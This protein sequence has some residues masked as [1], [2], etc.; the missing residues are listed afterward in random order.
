MGL[1]EV[2]AQ[3]SFET[4]EGREVA[5]DYGDA[6]A[7]YEAIRSN[8]ALID[9]SARGKLR[10]T[11]A[12]R[13]RFLHGMLTNTVEDVQPGKGNHT[14]LTDPKGNTQADLHLYNRG[15]AMFL[16]F[17]P[18]LHTSAAAFLDRYL[19]GDDVSIEDVSESWSVLGIQGPLSTSVL[20][21][22]GVE[23]P[24]DDHESLAFPPCPD[25]WIVKRGYAADLGFDVWLPA[26]EGEATWTRLVEAGA[27][28][29]GFGAVELRRIERGHPRYG[30]DVDDRVVPLEGGLADTVSFTKGCFIGQE[31]LAKMQNLGKPRRYLVGL[32]VGSGRPPNRGTPVFNGEKEVGD[33]R[34]ST[35][36]RALGR[37]IAL[38]S[39]R[40][41]N[42]VPG[43]PLRLGED[44][45]ATVSELPFSP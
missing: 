38:A 14:A 33:V 10:V 31:T 28:P 13:A 44:G 18:D 26:E 37:T 16:E 20:E 8:A 32:E 7:E 11:G 21:V 19:I 2:Q 25:G 42:E 45:S 12:D 6:A 17:E 24:G 27:R 5:V 43:T 15:E 36:S 4:I 35:R 29:A 9:R 23:V 30:V 41:G 34:S 1:R 22:L 39:V 40:R 3:G